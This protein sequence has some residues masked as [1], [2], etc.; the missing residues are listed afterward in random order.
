L[1]PVHPARQRHRHHRHHVH[2]CS[3]TV[4]KPPTRSEIRPDTE[5]PTH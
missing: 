5:I 4:R 1:L 3:L 2:W